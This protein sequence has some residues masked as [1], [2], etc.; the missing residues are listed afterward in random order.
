MNSPHFS[1]L[2]DGSNLP[3]IYSHPSTAISLMWEIEFLSSEEVL[4][5]VQCFSLSQGQSTV[6]LG[7]GTGY[8]NKHFNQVQGKGQE[9][10]VQREEQGEGGILTYT[11]VL[12]SILYKSLSELEINEMSITSARSLVHLKEG[13]NSF[14]VKA[15][16]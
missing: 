7:E 13:P 11:A 15:L 8:T 14:S 10:N 16:C 5:G 12:S 3:S 9:S 6:P 1:S 4:N 2:W